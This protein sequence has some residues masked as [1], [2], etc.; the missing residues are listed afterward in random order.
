MVV[1]FAIL[2]CDDLFVAGIKR[3]PAVHEINDRQA[4][5]PKGNTLGKEEPIA[6]GAAIDDRL[7]HDLDDV[8]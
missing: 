5:H 8:L 7:G 1:N 3:L 6:I 4:A 2:K